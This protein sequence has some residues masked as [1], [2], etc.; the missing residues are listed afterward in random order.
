MCVRSVWLG[1]GL[2]LLVSVWE[3]WA[4]FR[5]QIIVQGWNNR[6]YRDLLKRYGMFGGSQRQD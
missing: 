4:L 5:V 2:I 3:P 1:L 6:L